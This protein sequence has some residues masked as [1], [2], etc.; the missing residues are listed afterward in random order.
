[1]VIGSLPH[2]DVVGGRAGEVHQQRAILLW[3]HH[4]Q[5]RRQPDA[6][7][8]DD[9][10]FASFEGLHTFRQIHEAV[11]CRLG[12]SGGDDKIEVLNRVPSPTEAPGRLGLRHG[13]AA[14]QPLHNRASH[15]QHLA[16]RRALGALA[17]ASDG[18]EQ[19]LLAARAHAGQ[20]PQ[21]LLLRRLLQFIDARQPQFPHDQRHLLGAQPG[22]VDHIQHAGRVLL[23]QFAMQLAG[24]SL[25]DFQSLLGNGLADAL[26]LLQLAP[27][28]DALQALGQLPHHVHGLAV[29][30]NLEGVLALDLQQIGDL[31]EDQGD[32]CVRHASTPDPA[33]WAGITCPRNW[34]DLNGASTLRRTNSGRQ[35]ASS[36]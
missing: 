22:D 21:P 27:A 23:G 33:G 15:G 5:V 31:L 25:D 26:H 28:G 20:A 7:A 10:G 19:L 18:A 3:L 1:M 4:A 11:H 36:G 9:L 29:G 8:D 32:R 2:G 24:P 13:R 14:T 17:V 34:S 35:R 6:R 12:V 16:N 30:A